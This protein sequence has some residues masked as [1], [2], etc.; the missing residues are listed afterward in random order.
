MRGNLALLCALACVMIYPV[1]FAACGSSDSSDTGT[2]GD[3]GGGGGGGDAGGGGGE[4]AGGGGE[5]TGGSGDDAGGGTITECDWS[6]V[7]Y[8][9]MS[10]WLQIQ[11]PAAISQCKITLGIA[12][13]SNYKPDEVFATGDMPAQP[14][15]DIPVLGEAQVVFPCDHPATGNSCVGSEGAVTVTTNEVTLDDLKNKTAKGKKVIFDVST[16]Q[17]DNGTT[18]GEYTVTGIEAIWP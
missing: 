1:A 12:H 5:D 14:L 16:K 4:D 10:G 8:D 7:T 13:Y 3:A 17:V 15:G 6:Q 18:L 11:D 2:A 9:G